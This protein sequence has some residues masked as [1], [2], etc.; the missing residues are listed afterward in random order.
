MISGKVGALVLEFAAMPRGKS[1]EVELRSGDGSWER[2]A[3][4][5]DDQGIW[6]ETPRGCFGFDVR[7]TPQEEGPPRYEILARKRARGVAGLS[8]LRSGEGSDAV[9]GARKKKG[10]R[11]KS[12]MPGKIVRILVGAAET[13]KKGQPLLVMEAMKMEN[14][15]KSPQDGIVREIRV[16]EGQAV[17]TGA[18]LLSFV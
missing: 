2:V 18:E 4:R 16:T 5:R 3:W 10:A 1:G 15:I 11:L 12:Q 14:E 6:I 17:E 9:A 7:K 13:V 8:F